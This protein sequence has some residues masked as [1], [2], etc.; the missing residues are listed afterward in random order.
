[1]PKEKSQSLLQFCAQMF[2]IC[3]VVNYEQVSVFGTFFGN[4]FLFLQVNLTDQFSEVMLSNLRARGL[5]MLGSETCHDVNTQSKRFEILLFYFIFFP[6]L[7]R[8]SDA[9]YTHVKLKT[10]QEIWDTTLKSAERQR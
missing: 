8:F 3:A 1:M 4:F 10:M 7:L 5:T 6:F 2:P 9:G